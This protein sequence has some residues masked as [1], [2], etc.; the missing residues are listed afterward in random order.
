MCPSAHPSGS[1]AGLA[2]FPHSW[3]GGLNLPVV[4]EGFS[5]PC[6]IT[7]FTSFSSWSGA[8]SL[9]SDISTQDLEAFY[10]KMKD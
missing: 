4:L 2:H 8:V 6:A 10:S 7:A 9:Q 1:F 5:I 3:D